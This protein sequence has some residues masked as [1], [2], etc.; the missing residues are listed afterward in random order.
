MNPRAKSWATTFASRDSELLGTSLTHKNKEKSVVLNNKAV[1]SLATTPKFDR[2][3][4]STG[5]SKKSVGQCYCFCDFS[6]VAKWLYGSYPQ[7]GRAMEPLMGLLC[8]K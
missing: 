5:I 3:I 7:G 8:S 6:V 1:P 4:A 2:Q